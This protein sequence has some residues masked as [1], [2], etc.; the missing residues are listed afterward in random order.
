MKSIIINWKDYCLFKLIIF[1]QKDIKE[2]SITVITNIKFIFKLFFIKYF[3]NFDKLLV[4]SFNFTAFI[5]VKIYFAMLFL[6]AIKFSIY[7]LKFTVF[8]W[9]FLF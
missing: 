2:F 4:T 5:D 7:L 9:D 1:V 3:K 8:F 6:L